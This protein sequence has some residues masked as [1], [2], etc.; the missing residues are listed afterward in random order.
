MIDLEEYVSVLQASGKSCVTKFIKGRVPLGKLDHLIGG[1]RPLEKTLGTIAIF[2]AQIKG[3]NPIW[4]IDNAIIMH[5]NSLSKYIL[6]GDSVVVNESGGITPAS[7][8]EIINIENVEYKEQVN[9]P[10]LKEGIKVINLENDV[11][12]EDD[13]V[14]YMNIRFGYGEYCV[15]KELRLF[16]KDD[17]IKIFTEFKEKGGEYVYVYTTGIDNKQ[18]YEYSEAA[19]L[20]GLNRFIFKFTAGID[21]NINTFITWLKS[22]AEVEVVD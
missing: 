14:K 4:M 7:Y 11:Y 18:M 15:I 20:S 3:K 2:E 19:L 13:A 1:M 17:L 16:P 6:R 5:F 10:F 21:D 12:L 8:L 9:Y 22:R